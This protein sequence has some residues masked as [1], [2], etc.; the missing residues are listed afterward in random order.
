MS[1]EIWNE[2]CL[3]C[4]GSGKISKEGKRGM[5]YE[6]PCLACK[7]SGIRDPADIISTIKGQYN[8][9]PLNV[10]GAYSIERL[11]NAGMEL[12]RQRDE[13][14]NQKDNTSRR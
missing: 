6:E 4:K 10:V 9:S 13:L 11:L 8:A 1:G 3:N 14:K 12:A 7:G 5:K 2:K